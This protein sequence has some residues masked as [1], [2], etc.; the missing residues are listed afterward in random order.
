MRVDLAYRPRAWQEQCHRRPERFQVLALHRRA[1]KT[2]LASMKLIHCALRATREAAVF[3]YLAPFL[4]Q[5]K[6]IAWEML[7]RRV[8]PLRQQGAVEV[9]EGELLLRFVH[10]GAVIRLYGAD[11]PDALRG[12]RLD[13]V[14]VDEVAQIEPKL[15]DEILQPALSDRLGWAMFIGTP[16][17]VNLFSELFYKAQNTPGWFAGRWTVYDTGA[18]D[19]EEVER[20]RTGGMTENAFAREYLCDFTASGTDQLISLMEAEA[21]SRRLY[22]EAEYRGAARIMAVDPARFGDDRATIG[23]R[24]GLQLFPIEV[25]RGLS[26]M[27]LAS[28]VANRI[29][30]WKP[31]AVFIDAGAGS[32]VIDRLRQ[33]GF[34]VVEVN[35]GGTAN[36]ADVYADKRT[37]MAAECAEW[38]RQGGA[39]PND[40]ELKQE[41]ATPT[42]GYDKKGNGRRR[43]ESKDEIRKRLQGASPDKAD[44]TFLTFANPVPAPVEEWDLDPRSSSSRGS[45]DEFGFGHTA[46]NALSSW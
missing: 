46:G 36:R 25:H 6:A 30:R 9:N 35:F 21:A 22:A 24:Q 32:G 44:V 12:M 39:I 41:L 4:K 7:K 3:V 15:W 26:N 33:L 43:L 28:V 8:E 5:A 42:Y 2:V 29:T 23:M 34:S 45:H 31:H 20:L 14:V 10:N 1:G 19:P 11:N 37:E 38:L 13:G 17:G 40:P 27:D 18:I 16:H